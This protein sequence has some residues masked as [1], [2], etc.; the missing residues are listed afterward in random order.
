MAMSIVE[1]SEKLKEILSK[2]NKY[3]LSAHFLNKDTLTKPIEDGYLGVMFPIGSADTY[4][5]AEKLQLSISART[6][7]NVTIVKSGSYLPLYVN[8]RG[9]T[10]TYDPEKSFDEIEKEIIEQ[11]RR[12]REIMSTVPGLEGNKHFK[13]MYAEIQE[14]LQSIKDNKYIS[15]TD[16]EIIRLYYSNQLADLKKRITN[17]E[18]D[19]EVLERFDKNSL[20][21]VIYHAYQYALNTE[22]VKEHQRLADKSL[23]K[24]QG[25]KECEWLEEAK[26][27]LT[28][29]NEIDLYELIAKYFNN[30]L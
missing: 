26:N 25:Y 11:K 29:R 20:S 9:V 27:R 3:Y 28:K 16:K 13:K 19:N 30:K 24:V 15:T 17:L 22:K 2:S 4:E 6:G 18:I 1:T 21:Y 23:K 7:S 8:N 14:K 12:N 5:E 10:Y